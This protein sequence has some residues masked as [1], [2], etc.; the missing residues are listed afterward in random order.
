MDPQE[1]LNEVR[2]ASSTRYKP[3]AEPTPTMIAG[4]D[5]CSSVLM[6]GTPGVPI[7]LMRQMLPEGEFAGPQEA[8]PD[9]ATARSMAPWNDPGRDDI[10]TIVTG[11]AAETAVSRH[12]GR[13][14]YMSL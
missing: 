5:N 11:T 8:E 7:V 10:V 13:T 6:V 9:Q 14:P 1:F 4:T 3:K 2:G 12:I